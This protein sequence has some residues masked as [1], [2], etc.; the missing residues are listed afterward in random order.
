M[1]TTGGE[2]MS[3]DGIQRGLDRDARIVA[4]Q[5]PGAV[6]PEAVEQVK[7]SLRQFMKAQGLSQA[8]AAGLLG[9]SHTM[10]SEF[11]GGRYKGNISKLVNRIVGL[12]NSYE[13]KERQAEGK[14]FIETAV[15]KRIHTLIVQTEAFSGE[16]G[17]IGLIVGDGGHGKSVC[18]RQYTEANKNSIYVSLDATMSSSGMFAE[19]ARRLKI[20]HSGSLGVIASRIARMLRSRQMIILLDEASWLSVKQM[21]QLRQIVVIKGRCPLVLAGNE[22][23][24]KTIVQQTTKRGYESLDQ[25]RSRVVMVLNLDE[26]ASDGGGGLYTPEEVRRLY[27]YGGIRL[28]GDAVDSLRRICKTPKSGRL[29]TCSLIIA[30]LHRAGVVQEAGSIDGRMI[31]AAISQLGLMVEGWLPLAVDREETEQKIAAV[32]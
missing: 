5:V 27:E 17:K 4:E 9:V 1:V 21:D 3:E 7:A 2:F 25:F 20:N 16:E 24:L 23:L 12:V 14:R 13:R 19:I 29:R 32:G 28:I 31:A 18:L 8:K 26:L 30:A 11:L 10:I 6:T 22:D 15:A